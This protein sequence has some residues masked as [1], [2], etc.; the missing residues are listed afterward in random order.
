MQMWL[1]TRERERDVGSKCRVPLKQTDRKSSS[2][3]LDPHLS[4][5]YFRDGFHVKELPCVVLNTRQQ[6]HSNRISFALQVGEY[7]FRPERELS[8]PGLQTHHARLRIKAFQANLWLNGVLEQKDEWLWLSWER[9]YFSKCTTA[10]GSEL[11]SLW[12][13]WGNERSV[14]LE[15]V[16]LGTMPWTT[17]D[18]LCTTGESYLSSLTLSKMMRLTWSEGNDLFSNTIL[19]LDFVGS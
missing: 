15:V 1:W 3:G 16:M 14:E 8:L 4:L 13:Q 2:A 12:H 7:V 18:S 19:C 11:L 17:T 10:W 6:H 9:A 5:G